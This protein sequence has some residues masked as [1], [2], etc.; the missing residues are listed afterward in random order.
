[1]KVF[2]TSI[3]VCRGACIPYFKIDTPILCC[4]LFFKEYLN[5]LVRINKMGKE[6]T[7]DYHPSPSKLTSRIHPLVFL[8]TSKRFISPEYFLK[9]SSNLYIYP[10]NNGCGK[11]APQGRRGAGD[12]DP[13][14]FEIVLCQGLLEQTLM[15]RKI[16]FFHFCSFPKAKLSHRQKEIT[17]FTQ[18]A[19]SENLFFPNHKGRRIMELKKLPKLNLWEY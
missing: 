19:F 9:F 4:L 12:M 15:K 6:H 3:K 7:V 5:P 14:L 10:T 16:E 8:W 18:T 13:T 2:S 17:H 1:M 11:Q